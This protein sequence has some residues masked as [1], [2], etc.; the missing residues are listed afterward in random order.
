MQTAAQQSQKSTTMVNMVIL[1]LF[2]VVFVLF[3]YTFLHES[4]H[5][6]AGFVFGQKLTEFQIN[7]LEWDA[8]VGMVGELTQAQRAIQS[9]SGA[10]LPLLIWFGLISLAPRKATFSLEILK[11]VGSMVVLNTLLA[12]IAL[13]ILY[14]LGNALSDDVTNFLRYSEMPPLLLTFTAAVLYAR[15]WS[16]F[17]SR[18]DGL[19]NEFLLFR[20]TNREILTAGTRTLIPVMIGILTLTIA[21]TFILNGSA[22][23]NMVDTLVPP[24]DF[25]RVAQIDLSVRSYSDETLTHFSVDEPTYVGVFIAVRQI[26]TT[27]FDLSVTG[28]EGYRSV[29]LHGEGYN[30]YQDGGLW[31]EKLLPGIY[32]LVLNAHQSP[33]ATSVYLKSH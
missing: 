23:N 4:G 28:P 8:H 26:N 31:E 10:G 19:W 14:S 9:I 3:V 30:A 32:Q 21:S 33:G 12:W 17:L 27:Y 24:S 2:I 25:V 18:I 13:P 11:L 20:T 5:A 29:V 15:G 1:A 22:V 6:L 7:F 16:L